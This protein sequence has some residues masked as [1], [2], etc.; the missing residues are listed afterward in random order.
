MK[1]LNQALMLSLCLSSALV[2]TGCR[3]NVSAPA[4]APLGPRPPE[5][6][7][8]TSTTTPAGVAGSLPGAF[9]TGAPRISLGFPLFERHVANSSTT[10]GTAVWMEFSWDQQPKTVEIDV[11][12]DGARV[13]VKDVKGAGDPSSASGWTK[14][15]RFEMADT[16][17]PGHRRLLLTIEVGPS[18]TPLYAGTLCGVIFESDDKLEK[19]PFTPVKPRDAERSMNYVELVPG[20]LQPVP[21]TGVDRRLQGSVTVLAGP[22]AGQRL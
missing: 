7:A 1:R 13:R 12:Y 3:V 2:S 22:Q 15:T 6:A 18:A 4:S 11:L 21:G 20:G 9:P 16:P 5:A 17:E 10:S 14:V 8:P 19:L